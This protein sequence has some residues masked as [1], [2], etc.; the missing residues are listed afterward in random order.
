MSDRDSKSGFTRRDLV[1]GAMAGVVAAG[2][3]GKT[4]L[5]AGSAVG[6]EAVPVTLTVNGKLHTLS[7]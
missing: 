2:V 1:R 5:P 3:K 7:V 4:A 6:P